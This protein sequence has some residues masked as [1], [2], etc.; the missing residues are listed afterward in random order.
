MNQRS[1]NNEEGVDKYRNDLSLVR[2]E[3]LFLKAFN[4]LPNVM[5]LSTLEGVFVET[6]AAFT[7]ILGYT[8]EEAAGKN[9]LHIAWINPGERA[10]FLDVLNK[11][12]SIYK[13]E[14]HFWHKEGHEVVALISSVKVMIGGREY[15][16]SSIIDITDRI[17]TQETLERYRYLFDEVQDNIILINMKNGKIVDANNTALRTYGYTRDEMLKLELG[18]LCGMNENSRKHDARKNWRGLLFESL[19]QR[20]DGS[21]FYAEISAS[22]MTVKKH[23]YLLC[24]IRDISERKQA[25]S[26]RRKDAEEIMELYNNAPCGY[27]SLDSNN[28]ILRIN[29]TL[30]K[31]LGVTRE[32]VVGKRK[33]SEFLVDNSRQY[34][35]KLRSS[36]RK[37]GGAKGLE[38]EIIGGDGSLITALVNIQVLKDETGRCIMGNATLTDTTARKRMERSVRLSEEK[39]RSIFENA[40]EGMFQ[41]HLDRSYINVNPACASMFGYLSPEEMLAAVDDVYQTY[42]SPDEA[43]RIDKLLIEH[44]FIRDCIVKRLRKDKSTFWTSVNALAVYDESGKVRWIEGC[45]IDVTERIKHL[46]ELEYLNE[47]DP[48]TGLNNRTYFEK[49]LTAPAANRINGILMCDIDGLKLVNDSIGLQAGDDLLIAATEVLK[50]CCDANDILA[51]VGG[52]E[53]A[54][55]LS[56]I[57]VNVLNKRARQ[58][59]KEV[60]AYNTRDPLIPLCITVGVAFREERSASVFDLIKMADNNMYRQKLLSSQSARSSIVKT[61][62]KTLEARDFGTENHAVRLA[63]LMRIFANKVGFPLWKMEDLMLFSQ[64][65]DIGKVGVPDRILFKPGSLDQ[66]EKFEMQKHCEIGYRIAQSSPDLAPISELILQHHEWWNGQGYPLGLKGSEIPIGCRMLSIVD[67]YDAMT[68]DRP[69][70][71]AMSHEAAVQELIACKG[72]QFDPDLVAVFL[73]CISGFDDL[74]RGN[75]L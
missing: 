8:R 47:H 10:R 30:I 44:G 25:E 61:L 27:V 33:L 28:V 3:E 39:Y 4:Y 6:N 69:Y 36:L 58:I 49:T 57:D 60:E 41:A 37:Q 23:K 68:S 75:H 34:S 65:H 20:R 70:R 67:A 52:D 31:W 15:I 48:L 12:G 55:L 45:Y 53:F 29:D 62:M 32:E 19:H 24:V 71:R 50:K 11:E 46:E 14:A 22:T 63:E 38:L 18:L 42:D 40:V 17:N 26:L 13:M 43:E 66:E 59:Q 54:V 16:L 2:S 21:P 1:V 64:F 72:T 5:I 56:D 74:N 9:A 35:K 51:R 7:E 73:E